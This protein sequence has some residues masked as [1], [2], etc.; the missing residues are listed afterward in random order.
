M[1]AKYH[2]LI[3]GFIAI[4]I[5]HDGRTNCAGC[6]LFGGSGVPKRTAIIIANI[7]WFDVWPDESP[8]SQLH[9]ILQAVCVCLCTFTC[10]LK[11]YV[12]VSFHKIPLHQCVCRHMLYRLLLYC[13]FFFL[14]IF[15]NTF[16]RFA[17]ED[18]RKIIWNCGIR[19]SAHY[20]NQAICQKVM[21]AR[22]S[23]NEMNQ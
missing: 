10:V 22:H 14:Y 20:Y 5:A 1:V 3:L 13:L 9:L 12:C 15:R 17:S 2:D 18:W 19:N 21:R 4:V 8:Y 7:L 16:H 6:V 23:P 11:A